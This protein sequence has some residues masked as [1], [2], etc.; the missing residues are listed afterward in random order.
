MYK[1]EADL[2]N[3]IIQKKTIKRVRNGSRNHFIKPLGLTFYSSLDS[4]NES[5]IGNPV[6]E[7]CSKYTGVFV[8]IV[9]APASQSFSH[10][11]VNIVRG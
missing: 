7:N 1:L 5:V 8:T 4:D 6:L 3:W 11:N 10:S 2:K 9:L